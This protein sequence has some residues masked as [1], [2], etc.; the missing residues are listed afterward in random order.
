MPYSCNKKRENTIKPLFV[1]TLPRSVTRSDMIGDSRVAHVSYS[2]LTTMHH[3]SKLVHFC[4]EVPFL[5]VLKIHCSEWSGQFTNTANWHCRRVQQLSRTIN[6]SH[7]SCS[8]AHVD[9]YQVSLTN[10]QSCA[11]A[12]QRD[13]HHACKIFHSVIGFAQVL[14]AQYCSKG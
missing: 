14:R 7:L 12:V 1:S 8:S 9:I 3:Y 2:S 6:R 5:S 13:G 4:S 11:H 10:W